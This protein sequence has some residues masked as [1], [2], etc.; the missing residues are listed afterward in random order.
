MKPYLFVIL[1]CFFTSQQNP[2]PTVSQVNVV[3]QGKYSSWDRSQAGI[4]VAKNKTIYDKMCKF[5]N[6][7]AKKEVRKFAPFDDKFIYITAFAP[8]TDYE[9][10]W[11][12]ELNG[13]EQS[14]DDSL[15]IIIKATATDAKTS[16]K[17]SPKQP[18]IMFRLNIADLKL[19]QHTRFQLLIR[20]IKTETIIPMEFR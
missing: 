5:I 17:V 4:I 3:S 7:N 13:V 6:E 11:T 14:G 9:P 20:M 2:A 15:L 1:T 19:T 10:G 8:E 18:W 16:V 12:L